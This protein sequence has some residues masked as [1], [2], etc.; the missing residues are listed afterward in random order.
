MGVNCNVCLHTIM[1]LPTEVTS[2]RR[3]VILSVM[4]FSFSVVSKSYIRFL[5][6]KV[7]ILLEFICTQNKMKKKKKHKK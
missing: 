5:K 3:N 4:Y 7:H 2:M 1:V 6:N